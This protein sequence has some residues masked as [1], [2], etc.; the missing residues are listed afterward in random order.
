MQDPEIYLN[1]IGVELPCA[2]R[3][4]VPARLRADHRLRVNHE[5]YFFSSREALAEF[6]RD[7]LALCGKVTDP[8]SG[9][10]IAPTA[11]TP[12]YDYAGRSYFFSSWDTRGRFA[13]SP[14][15]FA[16]ASREMPDG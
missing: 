4:G 5:T 14:A 12:R 2:V 15:A 11:T 8:V 16:N 6:E 10:R 9:E 13:S 1:E 7:P 3:D